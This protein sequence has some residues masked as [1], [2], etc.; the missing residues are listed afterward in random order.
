MDPGN[1]LEKLV[2]FEK[3]A[4][5]LD[6]SYMKAHDEGIHVPIS[7]FHLFGLELFRI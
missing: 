5:E 1:V 2:S 6:T 7:A 3:V 4:R